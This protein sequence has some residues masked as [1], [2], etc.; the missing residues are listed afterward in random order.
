[1]MKRKNLKQLVKQYY[2]SPLEFLELFEKIATVGYLQQQER[3]LSSDESEQIICDLMFL[4]H[5]AQEVYQ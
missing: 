2:P 4:R 5:L 3:G 1:M